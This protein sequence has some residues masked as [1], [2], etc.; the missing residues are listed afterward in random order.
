MTFLFL[1][2]LYTFCRVTCLAWNLEE[3]MLSLVKCKNINKLQITDLN[4]ENAIPY[5]FNKPT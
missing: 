3:S 4:Y 1:R 5:H 2:K